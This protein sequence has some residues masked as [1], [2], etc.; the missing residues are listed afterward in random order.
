MENLVLSKSITSI[1]GIGAAKAALLKEEAGIEDIEDLLYYIPRRYVDRSSFKKIVDCFVNE[2]VSVRGRITNITLTHTGPKKQR[3]EVTIDDDSD[4]LTGVF[5]AGTQY[6]TK[7]FNEGDDVVFAGKI[8]F[9]KQKQIVHPDFDFLESGL[10]TGRIV[11]LYRSTEKLKTAR[12]DSRGFR[13]I[14][15]NAIDIHLTEIKDNLPQDLIKRLKLMTLQDAIHCIHFPETAQQAELAR[16]RL[17]FN[18]IFFLLF[19]LNLSR[20][21]LKQQQSDNALKY[22]TKLCE[23]FINSLPFQLTEEQQKAINEINADISAPFPMNR[24]LQG[25]VG[26]GKTVVSLATAMLPLALGRQVALMAPTELLAKQHFETINKFIPKF[27]KSTLL[28]G[29]NTASEKEE[30]YAGLADGTIGL[31]IGTHALIQSGVHFKDL[32]Y[33]VIDEQHRFGVEQRSRL[34]SKGEKTDLL[35][36]SATPIP[37]SLSMTIFGDMDISSIRQKP[38]GRKT[39][40]TLSL[41]ESRLKGVYNSMEK[42]ILEGRQIFYVLPLIEDS[43]KLDIKSAIAVYE[44]LTGGPF[45]HRRVALLHGRLKQI[46][47]D[48]IMQRFVKGEVDILVTTTVIEVGIDVP[49][50]SVIVIEH[51]QRFGLSQLHQLRGRVGRGSAASFCVLIYPDDISSDSKKRLDV[52]VSTD[53]GFVISEED[54]KLRGAGQ[55]TGVR[56]HGMSEFEFTD[57]VNDMDIITTARDEARSAAAGITNVKKALEDCRSYSGSL[58]NGIRG[59]RILSILS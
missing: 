52:L 48:D 33:I 56:Q 2:V 43:E 36:M 46:E 12:L 27:I 22:E 7:I 4:S 44:K 9:F 53:D 6:F 54:L 18:E 23:T 45:A 31:A 50:A 20:E 11:P 38:V 59:K 41:P 39:V 5:F 3:L 40:Q 51:S 15:K 8:N 24:L 1:Q 57:L 26:A 42:Y 13:R 32:A 37:R 49:N 34:R 28:T 17:A 30:I 55:L 25:D 35:V 58:V 19:Y 14:I 29:S 21:Y 16:K 47:K 10:N